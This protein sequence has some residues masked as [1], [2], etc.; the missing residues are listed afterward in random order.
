MLYDW[1]MFSSLDTMELCIYVEKL[2]PLIY[3]FLFTIELCINVVELLYV[4]NGLQ[5]TVG[6]NKE[7]DLPTKP[8][9]RLYR[10]KP[11]CKPYIPTIRYINNNNW[12]LLLF[13]SF[14]KSVLWE[15]PWLSGNA[16][17]YR[18]DLMSSNPPTVE[19]KIFC[20]ALALQVYSAH[21]VKWVIALNGWDPP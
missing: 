19:I 3:N 17:T 4:R 20:H 11:C 6:S 15:W 2:F 14:W 12:K 9:W 21:S 10:S 5:F 1:C 8:D 7:P 13:I 18:S 16:I